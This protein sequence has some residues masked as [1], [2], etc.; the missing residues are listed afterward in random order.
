M[1]LIYRLLEVKI[2][3]PAGRAIVPGGFRC[4]GYKRWVL[5]CK[6]LP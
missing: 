3:F 2:L 1:Y 4:N 6:R 5:R